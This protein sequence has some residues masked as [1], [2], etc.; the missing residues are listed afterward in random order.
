MKGLA[1]LAWMVFMLVFVVVLFFTF[2]W[3]GIM[4][5]KA[6]QVL[7]NTLLI[8]TALFL[9]ADIMISSRVPGP[10]RE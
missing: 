7:L 8:G 10:G 1:S 3:L 5:V 9:L 2:S 6:V 4:P